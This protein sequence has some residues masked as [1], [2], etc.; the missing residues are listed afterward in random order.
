[1]LVLRYLT[2]CKT[3]T[4]KHILSTNSN[5][6]NGMTCILSFLQKMARS[7]L[8]VGATGE[9]DMNHTAHWPLTCKGQL[10]VHP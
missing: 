8:P 10:D 7:P 3:E 4:E 2:Q 9:E 5:N 6:F 1:M